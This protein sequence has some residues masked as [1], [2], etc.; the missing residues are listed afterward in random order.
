[1]TPPAVQVKEL[2]IGSKQPV[3]VMG[4]INLSPE[5]FYKGSVAT[6]EEQ[7]ID[8]VRTYEMEGADVID[9]G[10]ASSSPLNVYSRDT[11]SLEEEYKRVSDF[12]GPIIENTSLPVSIDTTSAKVA[13]RALDLGAVMINDISGLQADER[14]GSVAV[15]HLVPVILMANCKNYCASVQ[16]S[17]I[18]LRNSLSIAEN[19]GIE[20]DRIIVDPGIGF[21]KPT[22]V[23]IKLIQ[24]LMT[25]KAF[26]RPVL[27]GVSR[28]AFLGD[29]LG[30]PN[31]DDRLM[32][33]IAA[34]TIGV[35][36]GADIIRAHDVK[37]ALV[38]IKIGQRFRKKDLEDSAGIELFQIQ[39][40]EECEAILER[41]GV[42]SKIISR[43][44]QKSIIL[45]I[46]LR[47]IKIPPALIIKQEMLALGGDA[48]YHHDTIDF[49]IDSTDVLIMGTK[50]QLKRLGYKM[51]KMDYFR[52]EKIGESILT[53]LNKHGEL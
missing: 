52:L 53:L 11:T 16:A 2:K 30:L 12:L 47:D 35:M 17:L 48:A 26:G 21:G 9:V 46:L 13:E 33:T 1:M 5:S 40:Y 42:S 22:E 43:L 4:V 8:M 45:N 38:A 18:A 14:M 44:A 15:E 10:A 25:F 29:V 20:N 31:P 37:E 24:K 36:N 6:N 51:K 49:G 7:L 3:R 39:D 27:V 19:T 41:I 32:G 34:T 23:D 28:K 50:M